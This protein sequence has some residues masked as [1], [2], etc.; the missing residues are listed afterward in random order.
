M[1]QLDHNNRSVTIAGKYA[2]AAYLEAV[3]E[4]LQVFGMFATGKTERW[5]AIDAV[6]VLGLG[7]GLV[8]AVQA[9]RYTRVEQVVENEDDI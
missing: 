2:L 8:W 1:I 9:V 6:D 3:A 7:V 4:Y 5:D